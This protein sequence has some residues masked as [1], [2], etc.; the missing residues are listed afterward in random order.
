LAGVLIATS[1]RDQ[2]LE[3]AEI[4]RQA[5]Y[6]AEQVTDPGTLIAQGSIGWPVLV[7]DLEQEGMDNRFFSAVAKRNPNLA[8]IGISGHKYHPNLGEAMSKCI[9][10]C[11]SKPVDEDEFVYLVKGLTSSGQGQN[12]NGGE[13]I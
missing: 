9:R 8:I 2:Y 7:V 4:L 6:K 13:W 10:A 5:G 12:G 1:D 3:M 11:L